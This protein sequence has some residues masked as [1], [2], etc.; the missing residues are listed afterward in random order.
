MI[1][2]TCVYYFSNSYIELFFGNFHTLMLLLHGKKCGH[3]AFFGNFHTL[4]LLLNGKNEGKDILQHHH[5]HEE[6]K[7][8][9]AH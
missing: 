9:N 4:M 5:F 7:V 8:L 1:C 3:R 2:K 6:N